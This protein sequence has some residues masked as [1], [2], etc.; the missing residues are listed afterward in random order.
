MKKLF[1]IIAIVLLLFS[2]LSCDS[3]L[4][5]VEDGNVNYY[6]YPYLKF[7]LSND[8][9]YYEVS[10]V[11]GAKLTSVSI[12][13]FHHT[14]FGP[15][16]IKVFKGFENPEDA[17]S[18][19]TVYIDVNVDRIADGAFDY[20]YSLESVITTGTSDGQYW[21]KLPP[22]LTRNGYHFHGWKV[23]DIIYDGGSTV[24][25]D[26]DSPVAEPYFIELEHHDV[27]EP[28]CTEEGNIEY[29]KCPECGKL[30]TDSYAE[31]SVNSVSVPLTGHL[32]PLVHKEYV[33]P[34]CQTEG[35][36]EYWRCDRCMEA[37]TD[38]TGTEVLENYILAKVPH[39]SDGETYS[40]ETVHY[41]KCRWCGIVMDEEAHTFG[42]WIIDKDATE[43]E[44][45]LKHAVCTEPGCGYVKKAWIPEHD[46]FDYEP[47]YKVKVDAT[48]LEGAYY[49]EKCGNPDCGTILRIDIEEEKAKGH[50]GTYYEYVAP[51]C[52]STGTKA[53]LWCNV[54]KAPYEN[55]WSKDKM[56]T[57]EVPL[58]AHEYN[59]SWTIGEDTHYHL[60]NTCGI[61]RSDE[62]KHVYK[63]VVDKKYL[64]YSSTCQHANQ[65]VES[66]ECGKEGTKLFESGEIGEHEYSVIKPFDSEYHYSYCKYCDAQDPTS[67]KKHTFIPS[68]YGKIC[69]DCN[70]EVPNTEGGFDVV[71]VDKTPKGHIELTSDDGTEKTFVFVNEKSA[72]PPTKLEWSVEGAIMR[73]DDVTGITDY[74]GYSF[75]ATTPYP[76]TYRITCRYSNDTAAGSSTIVVSGGGST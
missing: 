21:A 20:A 72:Y 8:L 62:T 31:N 25:L 32:Y 42:E 16:P 15:M 2:V 40:S 9:T 54:C 60:C 27:V 5:R 14:D 46:H 73:T 44:V 51:T 71:I 1:P 6:I 61:A 24:A 26:P 70:Y 59:S 57:I 64:K 65:Y 49:L 4:K 12:P 28:T 38:E 33:A 50:T 30:F 67:K 55:R 19:K 3:E 48:C 68:T 56:E 53:H 75:T 17:T 39:E 7:T 13:G 23:G 35:N 66:C 41:H 52:I 45:G 18:L 22:S 36:V 29:W 43:N 47:V 34:T 37:F 74:S 63:Q 58:K 69:K 11:E 10:V 76:M